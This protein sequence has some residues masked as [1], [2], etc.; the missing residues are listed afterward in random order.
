MYLLDTNTVIDLFKERGRVAEHVLATGAV[1]VTHNTDELGRVE[2][3]EIE[4]WF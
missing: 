3:L 2:G 4:D 1:L